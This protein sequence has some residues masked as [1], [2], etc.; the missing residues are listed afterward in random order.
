MSL[1]GFIRRRRTF[2]SRWKDD[3]AGSEKRNKSKSTKLNECTETQDDNLGQ[4]R[5]IRGAEVPLRRRRRAPGDAFRTSGNWGLVQ[6]P[7]NVSRRHSHQEPD[8]S[9]PCS[10]LTGIYSPVKICVYFCRRVF[11]GL[12]GNARFLSAA[13]FFFFFTFLKWHV[14][15]FRRPPAPAR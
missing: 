10:G 12:S 5:K 13:G 9:R 7:G 1:T 14:N 15:L 11:A 8:W 3:A 4:R 6:S 2:F